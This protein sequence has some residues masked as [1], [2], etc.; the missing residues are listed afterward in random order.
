M[1]SKETYISRRNRLKSDIGSGIILLNGNETVGMNYRD[2]TYHFRQDSTFL[3]FT[4]I[5]VPNL[6]LLIDI[7]NNTE[8]LFG[9]DPTID[10][11]VWMG[12]VSS[13]HS[14]AQTSGISKSNELTSIETTL[15]TAILQ[16]RK[17]HYIKPYRNGV[18]LKLSQ[19]L[20]LH[21]NAVKENNSIELTKAV[22][23]QRSYK[24]DE[25]LVEIEKAVTITTL[26]QKSAWLM[27]KEGVSEKE[28]AGH[29]EGIAISKGGHLSFPVILTANGQYLH[30]HASQSLLKQGQLILCD[31]GAE[32]AMHYAGDI[33]RTFPVNNKFTSIQKE[34][35][36]VVLYSQNAAIEALKPSVLFKDIHLLA[37]EKLIEGL[38]Q[39][40]FMKGDP[41]EAAAVGAHTLFF[42]CGLGHMMGLDVHDMENLGEE[43]IGY[44]DTLKK[45]TEFGLKS[46]RLGKALEERFVLTVEPGIYFIPELMDQFQANKKFTDFINYDKFQQFRTFG[47]IRLEDD[48]VITSNGSRILGP[49]LSKSS[50]YFVE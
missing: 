20:G 26:M 8:T 48:Y 37:C 23:A 15:K 6:Y 31:C 1:F 7:D 28:I 35:Y 36:D 21:P 10:D 32:T 22:I 25:E 46:L 19:Y 30:N 33:T 24:S 3:Y 43:Y 29:I 9:N 38:I 13:I 49:E 34:M 12:A 50:D 14:I 44:T 45:S 2:N 16:K 41:K 17:I 47:G 27:C 5:D 4:G 40:G 39:L 42:P 11:Q 18:T